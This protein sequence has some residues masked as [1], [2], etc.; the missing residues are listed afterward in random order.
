[1]MRTALLIV[2]VQNDYFPG[3]K[4]ELVGS[5]DACSRIKDLLV[6]FRNKRL[7]VIYIQHISMKPGASFFLPGTAGAEIYEAVKPLP[8]E[9]IVKKHAPN[10]FKNTE[11]LDTL[12]VKGVDRLVICGMMTHMCIDSTVRAAA[13]AGFDCTVAQDTCA[14]KDLFLNN[15][16]TPAEQVHAAFLAALNGTFAKVLS[17]GQV[18]KDMEGQG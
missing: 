3:G 2:D 4:N 12:K 18:L 8:G 1:M 13:E 17:T 5:N 9:V 14:T 6:A 10:S 16:V 15:N 7:P 11:L